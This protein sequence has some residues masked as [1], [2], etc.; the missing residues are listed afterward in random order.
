MPERLNELTS[1]F[2]SAL[3]LLRVQSLAAAALGAM[4]VPR[5]CNK[6]PARGSRS[7]ASGSSTDNRA[8]ERLVGMVVSLTPQRL[9]EVTGRT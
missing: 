2:H 9:R 4:C 7:N 6:D 3:S 1:L 8:V 5:G